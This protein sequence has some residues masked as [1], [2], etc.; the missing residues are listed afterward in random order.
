MSFSV[1]TIHVEFEIAFAILQFCIRVLT[2]FMTT[3]GGL[4][5]SDRGWTVMN[6]LKALMQ[7]CK[8]ANATS[9]STS[10]VLTENDIPGDAQKDTNLQN[11][12]EEACPASTW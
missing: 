3:P 10:G 12:K 7:S 5:T 9:N 4:K 2:T 6:V 1:R 11:L 8:M